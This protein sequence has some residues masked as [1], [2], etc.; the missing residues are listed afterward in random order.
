[1]A[2]TAARVDMVILNNATWIDAF[3]FGT[4]GDTSWNFNGQSFRMDIKGNNDQVTFLLSLT[5][6]AGTIVVDDPI[7]RILHLNVQDTVVAAA[8]LPGEYQYDFVMI[9][10]SVP[11]VRV[12]L[13]QGEVKVKQGITG[14]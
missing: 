11:P 3:Q 12:P 8:L 2:V 6:G 7:A 9:D 4:V 5:S 1:M 14:N 10:G 13:M